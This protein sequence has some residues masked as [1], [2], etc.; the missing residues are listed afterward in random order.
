M[1]TLYNCQFTN[2]HYQPVQTI[3]LELQNNNSPELFVV[4]Y[5]RAIYKNQVERNRC[6]IKQQ[7]SDY[8]LL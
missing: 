5:W 4:S 3:P 6:M 7:L 8:A 2:Q 1:N